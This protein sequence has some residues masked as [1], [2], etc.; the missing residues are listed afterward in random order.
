VLPGYILRQYLMK[1]LRTSNEADG[2][3]I[4][5]QVVEHSH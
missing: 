1:T 5:M 4:E 3:R 2:F